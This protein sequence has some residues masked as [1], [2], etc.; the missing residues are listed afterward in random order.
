ML[1]EALRTGH[2]STSFF[3][4]DDARPN[5][6]GWEPRGQEVIEWFKSWLD[7]AA[8]VAAS[9]N[10]E[11]SDSTKKALASNI[12]GIWRRVPKLRPRIIEIVRR[13]HDTSPWPECRHALSQML[14]FIDRRGENFPDDDLAAVH[15]LIEYT[16]PTDLRTR[17]RSEIAREWDVEAGDGDH[18][19]AD[20][21]RTERIIQLGKELAASSQLVK[22]NGRD[23]FE[24]KGRS[25]YSLGVGIARG[26]QSPQQAWEHLRDQHLIDPSRTIQTAILSGFIQELDETNSELADAIRA[27][28]RETA[29]LRRE[30]ALYLPKKV[31]S[32]DELNNVIEIAGEDETAAWLLTDIVWREE[33]ELCDEDRVRLLEAFMRRTDGPSLV[34]DALNMLRHVE[35]GGRDVWPEAIRAIGLEAVAALLNSSEL[36]ANADHDMA[37]TLSN[38]LRGDNGTGAERI[39]D[40]IIARAARRYGSTYD[41]NDTLGAVAKL[42][43]FV[44]LNRVFPD[45]AETPAVRLYDDIGTK[46]LSKISPV[47]LVSWCKGNADRWL[48][49]APHISPFTK[50][51]EGASGEDTIS[52]LAI[53]LMDAAPDPGRVLEEYYQNILPMGWSGS[54]ADIVER[55]LKKT[56]IPA[57]PSGAACWRGGGSTFSKRSRTN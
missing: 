29:E 1:R 31:L 3:F 11:T 50:N 43:P 2:W 47:D 27:E 10:P 9:S 12:D 37:N 17:L 48:R 42:A 30:Y 49:V 23:L 44:F 52:Q 24:A 8:E 38:C 33:R 21:R 51:T 46:P 6:S 26:S 45:G 53:A 57:R 7:L 13:I 20:R 4:Q 39:M 36:N 15:Q 32:A 5:A 35:S 14:Y 28:C 19:A 41:I 34:V 54:R 16:T 56:R 55:R 18:A 25:L 40:V 22:E